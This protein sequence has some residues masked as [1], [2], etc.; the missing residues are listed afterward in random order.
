MQKVFIIEGDGELHE[1]VVVMY[2]GFGREVRSRLE[3]MGYKVVCSTGLPCESPHAF[4]DHFMAMMEE[5]DAILALSNSVGSVILY[6][7]VLVNLL[8]RGKPLLLV[9]PSE[10]V[11]PDEFLG[12]NGVFHHFACQDYHGAEEIAEYFSRR[13]PVETDHPLFEEKTS[14]S[15]VTVP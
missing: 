5:C 14:G 15:Q 9:L 13:F 4:L 1:E 3:A 11:L 6:L 8:S 12:R 10:I 7:M 2:P